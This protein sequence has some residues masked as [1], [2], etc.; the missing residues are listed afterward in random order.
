M[1]SF[2]IYVPSYNRSDLILTQNHL[3]YCTYVVRESEEERYREAGVEN[4]WAVSDEKI[5]SVNKVKN[6]IIDNSL[7]DVVCIIDD[8]VKS[9]IYRIDENEKVVSRETVT[10]ELERVAQIMYDLNIGYLACPS[11]SNVKYYD[12]PFKFVGVNGGMTIYNKKALKSRLDLSLKFLSDIDL[13]L[14]ELLKNRIVIIP[15]YFCWQCSIDTNK[16]GS[17]DN[18]KLKDFDAENELLSQKWGKYYRKSNGGKA[19]RISVS[20]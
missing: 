10:R 12:R 13:Q 19:G 4:I 1:P 20:R 5:N 18:K 6:Y 16:G 15:N 2:N 9:V 8:D 17:N 11:D 3:E 14:H 7:E